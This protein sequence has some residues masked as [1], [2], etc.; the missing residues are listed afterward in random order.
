MQLRMTWTTQVWT[1]PTAT[2][3][4]SMTAS[5]DELDGNLAP[6]LRT[7]R[8]CGPALDDLHREHCCSQKIRLP[9]VVRAN[10]NCKV[11][12]CEVGGFVDAAVLAN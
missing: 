8:E 6:S 12:N 7:A 1:S 10:E 3:S 5:K 11:A 2:P 9:L 4:T